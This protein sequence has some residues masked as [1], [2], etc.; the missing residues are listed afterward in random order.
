MS[1]NSSTAAIVYELKRNLPPL[2]PR[3]SRLDFQHLWSLSV[4]AHGSFGGYSVS[5]NMPKWDKGYK[6]SWVTKG[7]EPEMPATS[8]PPATATVIPTD[9]LCSSTSSALLASS[10]SSLPPHLGG[11]TQ[12]E[13]EWI[14]SFW[15]NPSAPPIHLH[16]S[17]TFL[18]MVERV[19]G[20]FSEPQARAEWQYAVTSASSVKAQRQRQRQHQD[21]QEEDP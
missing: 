1:Y 20:H 6:P 9:A 15:Q 5:M 2:V 13:M 8:A 3:K 21:E 18:S 12:L 14:V 11:L 10:S 16:S 17:P 7:G 19:H 4:A